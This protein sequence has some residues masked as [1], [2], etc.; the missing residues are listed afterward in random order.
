MKECEEWDLQTPTPVIVEEVPGRCSLLPHTAPP[1]WHLTSIFA[2]LPFKCVLFIH[3]IAFYHWTLKSHDKIQ[4]IWFMDFFTITFCQ[5]YTT[6]R[7]NFWESE[8]CLYVI[9]VSSLFIPS[10]SWLRISGCLYNVQPS[11]S[12]S[13]HLWRATHG[14]PTLSLLYLVWSPQLNSW[15]RWKNETETFTD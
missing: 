1:A 14:Q 13:L 7:H 2:P 3:C 12:V 6:Q 8:L 10:N 11:V 4:F 5:I 15:C 9:T